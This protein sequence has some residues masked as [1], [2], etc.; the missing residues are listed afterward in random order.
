MPSYRFQVSLSKTAARHLKLEREQFL[1]VEM[2]SADFYNDAR[3]KVIVDAAI[4]GKGWSAGFPVA[5]AECPP[6]SE[7]EVECLRLALGC[8][9]STV[10]RAFYPNKWFSLRFDRLELGRK[11]Y[12]Y[13]K[14]GGGAMVKFALEFEDEVTTMIDDVLPPLFLVASNAS[15]ERPE[16]PAGEAENGTLRFVLVD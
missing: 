5:W 2:N 6:V 12:R 14:T 8:S 4:A 10:F 9:P 11:V 13:Q 3:R 16:P 1:F 15:E 7:V